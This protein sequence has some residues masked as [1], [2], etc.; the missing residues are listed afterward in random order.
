MIGEGLPGRVIDQVGSR[1]YTSMPAVR[2]LVNRVAE[3]AAAIQQAVG[4]VSELCWASVRDLVDRHRPVWA[5][6][7]QGAPPGAPVCPGGG[8][9]RPKVVISL[10]DLVP[11]YR[12]ELGEQV[13]RIS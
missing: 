6:G 10:D 9:G 11:G 13:A 5:R 8:S 1:D 2:Q 4:A 3:G 7:A 12:L